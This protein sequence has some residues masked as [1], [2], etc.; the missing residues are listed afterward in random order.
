VTNQAGQ[1][2]GN[3]QEVVD[4]SKIRE[5]LRMNPQNFIGSSVTEDPEDFIEEL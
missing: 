1:Q 2:R 3:R 5:F 4:T